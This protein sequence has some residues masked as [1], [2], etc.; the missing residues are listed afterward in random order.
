MYEYIFVYIVLP[1]IIK[2]QLGKILLFVTSYEMCDVS[3]RQLILKSVT[4]YVKIRKNKFLNCQL[5]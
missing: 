5:E 3:K 2:N 1:L 4:L